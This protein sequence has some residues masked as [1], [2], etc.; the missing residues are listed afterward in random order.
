MGAFD[1]NK[2]QNPGYPVLWMNTERAQDNMKVP[3]GTIIPLEM[4][5]D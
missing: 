5:E 1:W 3:F 4:D 2:I